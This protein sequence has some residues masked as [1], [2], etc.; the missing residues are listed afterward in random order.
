V[1]LRD[2]AEVWDLVD[3]TDCN[4]LLEVV[5][6]RPPTLD[7][8]KSQDDNEWDDEDWDEDEQ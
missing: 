1:N 2:N 7:Y 3:C 4:T 5:D 6:L 8:A